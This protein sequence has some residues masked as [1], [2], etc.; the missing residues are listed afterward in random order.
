MNIEL[1]KG[2]AVA[3]LF[4]IMAIYFGLVA[5]RTVLDLYRAG[6]KD[7]YEQGCCITDRFR[8]S[9]ADRVLGEAANLADHAYLDVGG[10]RQAAGE[11]IA[12]QICRLAE[13][14]RDKEV[15]RGAHLR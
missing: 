14:L 11:A 13:E 10:E 4:S 2:L 6:Y 3:V 12:R 9:V 15:E 8:S 7:G 5:W 1:V